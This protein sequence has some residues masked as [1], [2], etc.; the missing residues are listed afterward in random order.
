M[1]DPQVSLGK[2]FISICSHEILL[3]ISCYDG[4]PVSIIKFKIPLI[5]ST[6]VSSMEASRV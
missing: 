4:M 1:T 6:G 3:L 5:D 2:P